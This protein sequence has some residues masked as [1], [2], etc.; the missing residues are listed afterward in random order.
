MRKKSRPE[1]INFAYM[2]KN[3]EHSL[4]IAIAI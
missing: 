4:Y 3:I 1:P 2:R